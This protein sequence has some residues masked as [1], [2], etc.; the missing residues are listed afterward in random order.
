[1]ILAEYFP[2]NGPLHLQANNIPDKYQEISALEQDM[3]CI[4]LEKPNP[5]LT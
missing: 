1:M 5:E 3:L 2:Q 4:R